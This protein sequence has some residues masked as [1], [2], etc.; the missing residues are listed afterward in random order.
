MNSGI[1]ETD[2]INAGFAITGVQQIVTIDDE[3][4]AARWAKSLFKTER[5]RVSDLP[6]NWKFLT[7]RVQLARMTADP[8]FGTYNYQYVLP[9]NCLRVIATVDELGDD[10]EYKHRREVSVVISGGREIE[11]DV[12][13][14]N[15]ETVYIKYLRLRTDTATWPGWFGR[16]VSIGVAALVAAPVKQGKWERKIE[17]LWEQAYL[18]AQESN[19]ME[20]VDVDGN[21]QRLEKGNKDVAEAASIDITTLP[22]RR[23]VP[24]V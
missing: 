13:L 3:T 4:V 17:L 8:T 6:V 21:N 1:S 7:S 24:P 15:E 10:F 19:S 2:I 18:K 5:L 22:F 11:T 14:T 12:L 20:D 9:G 16:L 23:R